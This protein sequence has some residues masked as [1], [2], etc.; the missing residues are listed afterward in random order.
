[1]RTFGQPTLCSEA[2][3]ETK[4]AASVAAIEAL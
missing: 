3:L 4:K 1:M 2:S